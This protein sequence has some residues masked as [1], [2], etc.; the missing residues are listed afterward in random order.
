MKKN[1]I[2]FG[3]FSVGLGKITIKDE[4]FV[5][6]ERSKALIRKVLSDKPDI[7]HYFVEW[8]PC[9]NKIQSFFVF[10]FL[11]KID[12]ACCGEKNNDDC[13]KNNCYFFYGIL[14]T[15]LWIVNQSMAADGLRTCSVHNPPKG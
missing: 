2:N 3:R 7:L 13:N 11:I 8:I 9:L 12:T 14:L 4:L 10:L 15:V 5:A 6:V 1:D